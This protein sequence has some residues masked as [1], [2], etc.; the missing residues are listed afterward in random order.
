MARTC[1]TS[2]ESEDKL[3]LLSNTRIFEREVTK[4]DVRVVVDGIV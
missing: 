2:N 1:K 3:R 4:T